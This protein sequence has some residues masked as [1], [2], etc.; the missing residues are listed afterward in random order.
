MVNLSLVDVLT[1]IGCVL[2]VFLIVLI[3]E[4]GYLKDTQEGILRVYKSLAK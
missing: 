3:F 1:I 4:C 2:L